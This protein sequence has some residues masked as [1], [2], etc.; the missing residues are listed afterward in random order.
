MPAQIT[1][2]TVIASAKRF[3]LLRQSCPIS[4]SIAE[5]SVPACPRPNHQT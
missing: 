3:R 5:M 4:S 1:A 2:Q